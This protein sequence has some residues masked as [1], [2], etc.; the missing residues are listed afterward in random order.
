[1]CIHTPC[2][3]NRS[4][5]ARSAAHLQNIKG[6]GMPGSCKLWLKLNQGRGR[7]RRKVI[8]SIGKGTAHTVTVSELRKSAV[9][10][11]LM[12]GEHHVLCWMRCRLQDG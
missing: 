9:R 6:D 11:Q 5:V 8:G 12:N 10:Q 1:M 4:A 7:C 3:H 2:T